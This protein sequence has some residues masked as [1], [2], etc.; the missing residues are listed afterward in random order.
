MKTSKL[1]S[2]ICLV[3][4][5]SGVLADEQETVELGEMEVVGVTPLQGSGVSA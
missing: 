2:A 1:L 3:F 5:N 4:L